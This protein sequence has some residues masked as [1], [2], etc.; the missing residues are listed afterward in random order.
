MSKGGATDK[1][2]SQDVVQA[3][4]GVKVLGISLSRQ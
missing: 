3:V 1:N 4:V 2:E